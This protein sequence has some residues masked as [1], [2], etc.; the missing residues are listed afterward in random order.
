[1][2]IKDMISTLQKVAQNIVASGATC[3][4]MLQVLVLF[5]TTDILVSSKPLL[6]VGV[7][8]IFGII[9]AQVSPAKGKTQVVK[10]S[11]QRKPGSRWS[12]WVQVVHDRSLWIRTL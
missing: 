6:C 10:D 7:C 4:P 11:L 2:A 12:H 9:L 3:I 1:M 8:N 5:V